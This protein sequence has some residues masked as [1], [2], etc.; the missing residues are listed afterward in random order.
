M[1][2][3]YILSIQFY[4]PAKIENSL[5][6]LQRMINY[7]ASVSPVLFYFIKT[8]LLYLYVVSL[9]LKSCDVSDLATF[10]HYIE[11]EYCQT[12]PDGH[13]DR[14]S[15]VGGESPQATVR[16]TC[17]EAARRQEGGEIS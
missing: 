5:F 12:L 8:P 15:Q 10:I 14:A 4:L 3:V 2:T 1:S 7:V 9:V 16:D 17:Q 11:L 13:P 6:E